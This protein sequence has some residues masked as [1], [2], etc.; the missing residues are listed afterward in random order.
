[1][2]TRT[3]PPL[4]LL[5]AVLLMMTFTLS[6]IA[7]TSTPAHADPLPDP[8]TTTPGSP[9]TPG[10]GGYD[11]EAPDPAEQGP[12]LTLLEMKT[13]IANNESLH[14]L[15]GD[16]HVY[17]DSKGNPT[18]GIGFNLNRPGAQA[19]I[20]SVGANYAAVRAGTQDLTP[21][22]IIT[23]FENDFYAAIANLR[24]V[25]YNFDRLTSARQLVLIDMMYNM[26]AARFRE[27]TRMIAAV[28][29]GDFNRAGLE[30]KNSLWAKQVG[31][32]A[33]RNIKLM[34]QGAVCDPKDLPKGVPSTGV[35]G[36]AYP[37][38]VVVVGSPFSGGGGALNYIYWETT[39][40]VTTVGTMNGV[41][42][43]GT[44]Y[45]Y[46]TYS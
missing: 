46:T 23:L 45:C 32:R 14:G 11:P 25:I 27:F 13:Y 30:M 38:G 37:N 10:G 21:L 28:N 29:V 24:T 16:P 41:T 22:Q 31:A 3:T 20:E 17:P 18:V 43:E 34:Q 2:T 5:A 7:L 4:R 9:G 35:G 19:R 12:Q 6:A 33:T 36:A 8:C 26:G 42:Y 15:A 40:C 44:T 39:T 1:M